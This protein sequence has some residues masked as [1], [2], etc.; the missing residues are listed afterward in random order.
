[1]NKQNLF[2]ENKF[3]F[4]LLIPLLTLLSATLLYPLIYAFVTSFYKWNLA[5]AFLGKKFVGFSQYIQIFEDEAL[6]KALINTFFYMLVIVPLELILG[7]LIATLLQGKFLGK[8]IFQ[9]ILFLPVVLTPVGVGIIWKVLLNT[10]MG[11]IP[12]FL[13]VLGFKRYALLSDPLM[14]KFCIVVVDVWATTPFVFI[15]VL[16]A[17]SSLP[18]SPFEAGIIDGAS[19]WQ[20]FRYITFPLIKPVLSVVILIRAMDVFR[21]FDVIFILTG[22]GPVYKTESVFTHVIRYLSSYTEV[23]YS[24]AQAFFILVI[25]IVMS[26]I[27]SKVLKSETY[28]YE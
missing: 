20:I 2:A 14:A 28:Y 25:I 19:K 15:L 4:L 12:Y 5:R 9:T 3:Y 22:G 18:Q 24:C 13:D 7:T 23:G 27:I 17:L 11:A 21:I 26:Y 6:I 8:K 10:D 1:M 16:A